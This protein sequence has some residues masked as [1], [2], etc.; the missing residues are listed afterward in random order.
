[1]FFFVC[2]I[3]NAHR[4]SGKSRARSVGTRKN[5]G[6]V[7]RCRKQI[8]RQSKGDLRAVGDPLPQCLTA[9][10]GRKIGDLSDGGG[11]Y[12]VII[13]NIGQARGHGIESDV[14]V[15]GGKS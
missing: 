8:E 5:Q 4:R 13:G 2:C 12:V 14:S 6:Q 7:F 9:K 11:R 10:D 15:G 3:G 1:M